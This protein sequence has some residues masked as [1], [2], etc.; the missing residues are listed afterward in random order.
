MISGVIVVLI[1]EACILRSG[2]LAEWAV[3]FALINLIY[4]P[5]LEEPGLVARFGE[6]YTRYKRFVP[7]CLPR[8]RP[9]TPDPSR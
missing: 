7:R 1:G 3:L 5:L 6:P 9:W 8:L 4:I 2:P